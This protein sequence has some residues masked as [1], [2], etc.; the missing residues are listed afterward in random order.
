MY[1]IKSTKIIEE[2]KK[3]IDGSALIAEIPGMEKFSISGLYSGVQ[4]A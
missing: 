4:G 1:E 3:V 2:K